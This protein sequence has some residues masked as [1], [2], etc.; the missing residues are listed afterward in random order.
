MGERIRVK[1]K[2]CLL[3]DIAVGKTSLIRRFVLDQFDDKYISTVGTKVTKK[4]MDFEFPEANCSVEVTLLIW[5]I[6]GQALDVLESTLSQYERYLPQ[7]DF[8]RNAKAAI[9]V[10][11][12]TRKETLE[13]IADWVKSLFEIVGEVPLI[14]AC[15]KYDLMDQADFDLNKVMEIASKFK[16]KSFLTS[17]KSNDNVEE[18]FQTIGD[19]LS[20][21]CISNK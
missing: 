16:T 12:L 7:K 2:V 5:D 20:K 18:M 13:H 4:K 9:I 11:D 10:C 19:K 3:G 15:N 8:Y 6:M 21:E 1:G 17:A 14:F